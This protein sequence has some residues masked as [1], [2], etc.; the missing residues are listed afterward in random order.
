MIGKENKRHSENMS[1]LIGAAALKPWSIS[2]IEYVKNS[3]LLL[4]YWLPLSLF[5]S[6]V[7]V[8]S[9]RSDDRNSSDNVMHTCE[10]YNWLSL[11]HIVNLLFFVRQRVFFALV[12]HRTPYTPKLFFLRSSL[13]LVE[14]FVPDVNGCCCCRNC[15]QSR[16]LFSIH[17]NYSTATA[18]FS[19]ATYFTKCDR[20]VSTIYIFTN[21]QLVSNFVC[22]FGKAIISLNTDTRCDG[23]H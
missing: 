1:K 3:C 18:L 5:Y 17:S 15:Y 6:L 22:V 7:A 20:F 4:N 13:I 21:T 14:C 2:H 9:K 23:S 19:L 11:S 16:A 12:H 10:H 8:S